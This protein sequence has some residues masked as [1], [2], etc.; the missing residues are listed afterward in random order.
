MKDWC[1]IWFV[2]N[3]QGQCGH[4]NSLVKMWM[5]PDPFDTPMWIIVLWYELTS[6]I[7]WKEIRGTALNP[8]MSPTGRLMKL[9]KSGAENKC[10]TWPRGIFLLLC[11]QR[12]MGQGLPL[13]VGWWH[14][15]VFAGPMTTVRMSLW[16]TEEGRTMT[17]CTGCTCPACTAVA[18]ATAARP[19]SRLQ[20]TPS[21][22][23]LSQSTCEKQKC[24]II[25]FYSRASVM[26]S[27]C[28]L[29]RMRSSVLRKACCVQKCSCY[30]PAVTLK[31]KALWKP[32]RGRE[33]GVP[34]FC[35][36]V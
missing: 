8:Q 14:C 26:D 6:V 33:G 21:A 25:Y 13:V 17:T 28:C 12:E 10:K 32:V 35:C 34:C 11:H 24:C 19:P 7:V 4:G 22:M 29:E 3:I 1:W 27:Q 9:Y 2:L 20:P 36:P 18:A 15:L 23:R 30:A 5:S 16:A 31:P